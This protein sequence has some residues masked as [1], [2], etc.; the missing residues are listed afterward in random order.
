MPGVSL[1]STTGHYSV[2]TLQCYKSATSQ[3]LGVLEHHSL[4]A[5]LSLSTSS[6]KILHPVLLPVTR[7][8]ILENISLVAYVR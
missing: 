6:N 2:G 3:V 7:Y 1:G 5:K 8:C 4:S